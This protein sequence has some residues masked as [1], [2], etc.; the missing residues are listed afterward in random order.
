[1]MPMAAIPIGDIAAMQRTQMEAMANAGKAFME[2]VTEINRELMSFG[3]KRAGI[4]L[5][6][7]RNIPR[8]GEWGNLMSYQL[9]WANSATQAYIEEASRLFELGVKVSQK[10]WMPLQESMTA[11]I[12][13]ASRSDD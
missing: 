1:M 5:E 11:A 6:N 10:S 3:Q 8:P 7:S 9:D 2:G 12:N 4:L 13:S